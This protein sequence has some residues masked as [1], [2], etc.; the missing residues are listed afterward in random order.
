[1]VAVFRLHPYVVFKANIVF[2]LVK[3][4]GKRQRVLVID[5]YAS[6]RTRVL[7]ER[8]G[9]KERNNDDGDYAV[10]K[11]IPDFEK[12]VLFYLVYFF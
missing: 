11:Y 6:E 3:V 9:E 1:M 2:G 12:P 8:Y 5:I 4:V 10:D 7:R